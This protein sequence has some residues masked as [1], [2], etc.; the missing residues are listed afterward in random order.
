MPAE[1]APIIGSG[2]DK[3]GKPLIDAEGGCVI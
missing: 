1:L 2:V 3:D